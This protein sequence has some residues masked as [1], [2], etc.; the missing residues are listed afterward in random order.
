MLVSSEY[1]VVWAGASGL[2]FADLLVAEADV[3]VTV[4]DRRHPQEV[5]GCKRTRPVDT[6]SRQS[7]S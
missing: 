6:P 3:E 2:A 7:P 1:L 4:I 5:I